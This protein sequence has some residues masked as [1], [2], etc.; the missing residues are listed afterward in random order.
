MAPV[1]VNLIEGRVYQDMER[2]FDFL[3]LTAQEILARQLD[4]SEVELVDD[5][6]SRVVHAYFLMS[7]AY[8]SDK[9]GHR[10]P[11]EEHWTESP[12][13][14]ALTTLAIMLFRPLRLIRPARTLRNP[15]S[16]VAN[17]VLA[18]AAAASLME[19]QWPALTWERQR[20]LFNLLDRIGK[21]P[22]HVRCLRPYMRDQMK[23]TRRT[24][25][26]ID[27]DRDMTIIDSLI[28]LFESPLRP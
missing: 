11:Q 21:P 4:V 23:G 20:R 3:A 2:R 1:R 16:L 18:L 5:H 28:L 24:E 15:I 12:K 9:L 25:Y 13:K 8:K 22:L 27:L 26:D 10:E 19:Q 17:Q 14:A 7:E 6:L